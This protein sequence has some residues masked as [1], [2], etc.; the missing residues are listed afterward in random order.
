MIKDGGLNDY[1]D[2]AEEELIKKYFFHSDYWQTI[3]KK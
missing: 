3:K 1:F 2:N